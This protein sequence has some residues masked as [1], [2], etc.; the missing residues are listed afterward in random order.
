MNGVPARLHVMSDRAFTFTGRIRSFT[1]ALH[2]IAM[3]LRSQ[4]NAWVHAV[5]TIVA[6]IA[7]IALGI[8]RTEWCL[9]TFAIAGVWVAE[10]MNTAFEFLCDVASPEFHPTVKQAKDVAAG[11]VLISAIAA[12]AIGLLVFGPRLLGS[13]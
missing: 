11:A 7:S 13:A 3:T 5:A 8:S 10:A 12:V 6:I 1:H 4:H 9:I 2:G